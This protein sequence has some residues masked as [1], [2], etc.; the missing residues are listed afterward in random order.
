[1]KE[2]FKKFY[3]GLNNEFLKIGSN[4]GSLSEFTRILYQYFTSM[5]Q[6]NGNSCQQKTQIPW[7]KTY[8]KQ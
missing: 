2:L 5:P 6:G 7:Q 4:K 8:G 3:G 1:M